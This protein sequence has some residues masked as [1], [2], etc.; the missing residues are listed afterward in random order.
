MKKLSSFERGSFLIMSLI[1]FLGSLSY[2]F[3]S[4]EFVKTIPSLW[5]CVIYSL[6][7]ILLSYSIIFFF[8]GIGK[9][10]WRKWPVLIASLFQGGLFL[11]HFLVLENGPF[12]RGTLILIGGTS[13]FFF[14][15]ILFLV[16]EMGFYKTKNNKLN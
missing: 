3:P 6:S 12:N 9:R 13:L 14:L 1:L 15:A 2:I 4:E 5:P 7:W 16:T 8:I 11:E 10:E